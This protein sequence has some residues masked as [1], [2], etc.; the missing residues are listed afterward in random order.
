MDPGAL[1]LSVPELKY[2]IRGQT[3]NTPAFLF[4]PSSRRFFGSAFM[5][6]S[7]HAP[8]DTVGAIIQAVGL[9]SRQLESQERLQVLGFSYETCC[10]DICGRKKISRVT[11]CTV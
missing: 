5:G 10:L 6:S 3:I 2:H 4:P 9:Q 11:Q 8:N 7:P 1:R